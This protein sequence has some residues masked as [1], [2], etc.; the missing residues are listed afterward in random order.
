MFVCRP[1]FAMT[2]G[3]KRGLTRSHTGTDCLSSSISHSPTTKMRRRV[4]LL[5]LLVLM[6]P[7]GSSGSAC[8]SWLPGHQTEWHRICNETVRNEF[9]ARRL[10]K[11]CSLPKPPSKHSLVKLS[12]YSSVSL[13]STLITRELALPCRFRAWRWQVAHRCSPLHCA[14]FEGSNRTPCDQFAR[15]LLSCLAVDAER[16]THF[17]NGLWCVMTSMH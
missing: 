11:F 12:P 3:V 16:R 4:A 17:S 2:H 6:L 13:T 5:V 10:F 15:Y 14:R 7:T 1:V 8:D 9:A